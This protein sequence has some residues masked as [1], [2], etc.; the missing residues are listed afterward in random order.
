M[1]LREYLFRH[2]T[3]IAEFGRLI[4]YSRIHLSKVVNGERKP[5]EKLARAI[6]KAT[7]SEVTVKE[8]LKESDE[9]I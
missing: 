2:R 1:D 8:L 5:S 3:S 7:N 4:D 9:K 6:E